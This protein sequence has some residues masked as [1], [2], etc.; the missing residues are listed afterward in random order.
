MPE[1]NRKQKM[2]VLITGL[3]MLA[4]G[5]AGSVYALPYLQ[6]AR[7]YLRYGMIATQHII[8]LATLVLTVIF[9]FVGG[10]LLINNVISQTKLERVRQH[11]LTQLTSSAICIALSVILSQIRLYRMPQGGSVTAFSMLFLVLVGYWFGARAGF[12]AGVAC[13]LLRLLMDPFF[14]HPIQLLLDY[15]IAYALLGCFVMFRYKRFG[16]QITYLLGT[17]G[18]FFAHFIAGAVFFA[19][20]TPDGQH[21]I[22]FSAVY[23]LAHIGPEVLVTLIII[24]IPTVQAAI[25]RLTPVRK[26]PVRT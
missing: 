23:N 4:V 7:S 16:L 9:F 18:S 8:V 21:F 3:L 6:E 10:G 24:S 5:L 2:G 13:G 12:M 19:E 1:N 11:L 25:E 22:L 14:V 20:N 15:P 17:F 26:Q